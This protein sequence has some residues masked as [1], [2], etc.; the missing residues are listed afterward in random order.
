MW[1]YVTRVYIVTGKRAVIQ[2]HW[3]F[4]PPL[5]RLHHPAVDSIMQSFTRELIQSFIHSFNHSFSHSFSV[6]L[7]RL[8]AWLWWWRIWWRWRRWVGA[9]RFWR[10]ERLVKSPIQTLDSNDNF[11]TST[12][13]E[14]SKGWVESHILGWGKLESWDQAIVFSRVVRDFTLHQRQSAHEKWLALPLVLIYLPAH[15]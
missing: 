1:I 13:V 14:D 8:V 7:A 9:S 3:Y 5:Y 4:L 2:C 12:K 11:K 15:H 10:F 6:W